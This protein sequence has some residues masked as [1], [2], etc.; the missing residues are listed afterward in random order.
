MMVNLAEVPVDRF[1]LRSKA[2]I[3]LI[4]VVV[5]RYFGGTKLGV[6][7]LIRA[8]GGSAGKALDQVEI[9][10]IWET[11]PLAI[12]FAYDQTR[13]VEA[14]LRAYALVPTQTDFEEQVRMRLDVPD[15]KL[16]ELRDALV[17]Q[18]SGQIEFPAIE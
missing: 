15:E 10:T 17:Q 13:S 7:G 1:S 3:S 11:Q 18:T 12:I 16:G 4:V 2:T 6:G 14:V 8:Y 5:T 9:S